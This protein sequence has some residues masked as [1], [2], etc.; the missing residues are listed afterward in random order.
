MRRS[1]SVLTSRAT[2]VMSARSSLQERSFVGRWLRLHVRHLDRPALYAA[3]HDESRLGRVHRPTRIGR[4]GGAI[5]DDPRLRGFGVLPGG[6]KQSNDLVQDG[7]KSRLGLGGGAGDPMQAGQ[8]LDP[9]DERRLHAAVVQSHLGLVS[10]RFRGP[11]RVPSAVRTCTRYQRP[12]H[13]SSRAGAPHLPPATSG[14]A[15]DL[16]QTA[17][18][19]LPGRLEVRLPFKDPQDLRQEYSTRRQRPPV[20][21]IVS[22]PCQSPK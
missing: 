3:D 7:R 22:C 15:D 20:R 5:E 9:L 2:E 6:R 14:N 21:W 10:A 11:A 12:G 4:V 8:F 18:G 19:Y 13:V 1:T 16:T 17:Q